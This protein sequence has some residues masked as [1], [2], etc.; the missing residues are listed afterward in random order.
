MFKN[1]FQRETALRLVFERLSDL[2]SRTAFVYF[3][4]LAMI[5]PTSMASEFH[6]L[7][8]IGSDMP[9]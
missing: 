8:E 4:R 1:T 3:T 9:D 5:L 2:K 7:L 6:L